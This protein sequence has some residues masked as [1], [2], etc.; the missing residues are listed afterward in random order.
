LK[1]TGFQTTCYFEVVKDEG[2]I[3]PPHAEFPPVTMVI[4]SI[5]P[6]V[7]LLW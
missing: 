6:S 2:D 5:Q 7:S 4:W 3:I 1:T